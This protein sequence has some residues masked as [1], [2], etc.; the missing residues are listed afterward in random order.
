MRNIKFSDFA[1][2]IILRALNS[3]ER[4]VFKNR[5][6][7]PFDQVPPDL[8]ANLIIDVGANVGDVTI[9]ALKSYPNSQ[10]ICF[11]PVDRTRQILANKLKNYG[12]RITIYSE[13]L[14][15]VNETSFINISSFHGAN[16]IEPQSKLHSLVNPH[17]KET[18]K[19]KI[20]LVRLDEFAR[21]H[22]F[23]S[24]DILKIDVEGHELQ[25]LLGGQ[26]FICSN[27]DTVIIEVSLMRDPSLQ[28]QSIVDI[29]SLMRE[30]GFSLINVFDLH[31]VPNF[32]L[33]CVQMDCVFRKTSNIK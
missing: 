30:M 14:S 22:D 18:E 23:S 9:A 6:I 2:P 13:A 12:D 8:N 29:F 17:I 3:A 15:N 21:T 20:N 5:A 26:D 10:V 11:E 24:V 27:V 33:M 25:V 4:H 7:T 28:S 31:Y 19:Q 16:S 1:P 32:K